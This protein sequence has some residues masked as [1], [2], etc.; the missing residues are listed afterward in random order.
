MALWTAV[1]SKSRGWSLSMCT[2][3][4]IVPTV[5]WGEGGHVGG[6]SCWGGGHVGREGHVGGRG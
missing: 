4:S 5:C 1:E 2:P 6:E 3:I